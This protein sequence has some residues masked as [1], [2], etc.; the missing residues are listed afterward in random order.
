MSDGAVVLLK[1]GVPIRV[2]RALETPGG[3]FVINCCLT[4]DRFL[5]LIVAQDPCAQ[6]LSQAV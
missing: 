3:I 5:L 2:R 1:T 4:R 6:L